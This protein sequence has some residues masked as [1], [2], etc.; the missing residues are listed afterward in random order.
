MRVLV[1]EHAPGRADSIDNF[2]EQ[3]GAETSLWRVYE[4]DSPEEDFHALVL[5]GGP[6]SAEEIMNSTSPGF[7]KEVELIQKAIQ[8]HMPILGICLGCQVLTLAL[9]GKMSYQTGWRRG[10]YD[11]C[12][13]SYGFSDDLL[14]GMPYRFP[15]FEFH[16]DRVQSPPTGY[17]LL[18]QAPD[19]KL[20]YETFRI[21]DRPFWAFQGHIEI[22]PEKAESI[23]KA[24]KDQLET[25]G[26][27]VLAEIKKGYEIP[28]LSGISIFKGFVNV[29]KGS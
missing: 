26:V 2:L 20:N 28:V 13:T 3:A 15:V 24:R 7:Q 8:K 23:L 12:L 22:T 16:Q 29:I 5:S 4:D 21:I 19:P 9:H 14:K 18:A 25:E 27:D 10:W 6:M 17:R 11:Q 1:V